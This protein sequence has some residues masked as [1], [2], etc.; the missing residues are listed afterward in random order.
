PWREAALQRGYRSSI[1][2]PLK[3]E[4][5]NVFGVFNIYSTEPNAFTQDEIRLLEE[6]AEDMAF[7]IKVL[8]TRIER[9]QGEEA[10]RSSQQRMDN[11]VANSPGA[12]YRCTNDAEWTMEFLSAA[13]TRITGYSAED[14]LGNRI[15][16]Y[17]SIIHPDDRRIVREVVSVALEHKTQYQMDYRLVAKDGTPRWVHEQGQGLLDPDGRLNILDGFI[18]DITEQRKAEE[19][20]KRLNQE[21]EQRVSDRTRQ[22]EDAN[23]ELEAFAYSVSH[24]LRAPLGQLIDAI[25][26]FSRTG[27]LEISLSEID[28]EKM[29][30][31]ICAELQTTDSESKLQWKIEPMPLARGDSAMLRQV[32]VN[33]LSNAIKFSQ[34]RETPK[35]EVGAS[36]K[37]GETTY[38]VK[39]NGVGFDMRYVD[40]LFGVFQRLHSMNEFEG[41]GIGLATVKR[42]VT[43]HGGRVWAEGEVNKG[44]TFFFT[45]P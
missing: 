28:V 32:F 1:S 2:L 18:F 12:I 33:L 11:I 42:I 22:L 36:V 39:D 10:L 26:K 4:T 19:E 23:K 24:D 29:V 44:A 6:L 45:L 20:I 16:S 34:T 8:R 30:R 3:D 9:Q 31:S 5:A 27:R 41:T 13:I 43:R 37:D 35:I 40:K 7:G 38:F 15:R 25:L 14:F 17:A 21:L